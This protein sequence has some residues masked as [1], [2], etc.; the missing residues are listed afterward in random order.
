LQQ[1]S[2][3]IKILRGHGPI[4][5]C[6]LGQLSLDLLVERPQRRGFGY[7]LESKVILDHLAHAVHNDGVWVGD[8]NPS[9]PR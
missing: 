9:A 3:E 1:R 7:Y 6:N 5:Q 8:N 4:K 2:G